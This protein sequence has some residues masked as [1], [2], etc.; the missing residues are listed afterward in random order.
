MARRLHVEGFIKKA[1]RL[2]VSLMAPALHPV[3]ISSVDLVPEAAEPWD[4]QATSPAGFPELPSVFRLLGLECLQ[5]ED[6]APQGCD[7]TGNP[8]LQSARA[9]RGQ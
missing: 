3:K 1:L 6:L 7:R 2:G 9:S 8:G 4:N 5:E